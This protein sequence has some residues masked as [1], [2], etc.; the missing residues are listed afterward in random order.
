MVLKIHKKKHIS[1][2]PVK[3]KHWPEHIQEKDDFGL[4]LPSMKLAY[5]LAPEKWMVGRLSPFLLGKKPYF[6]GANLLA[7][8]FRL[9]SFLNSCSDLPQ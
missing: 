2:S 6:S 3:L 9:V 4:I 1:L 5:A 7:V 8:S